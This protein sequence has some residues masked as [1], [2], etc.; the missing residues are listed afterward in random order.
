MMWVLA[1]DLLMGCLMRLDYSVWLSPPLHASHDNR[2]S[3]TSFNPITPTW[4]D[5]NS[6]TPFL[7]STS[8]GSLPLIFWYSFC[9]QRSVFYSLMSWKSVVSSI[10]LPLSFFVFFSDHLCLLPFISLL[11]L[12][13]TAGKNQNRIRKHCPKPFFIALSVK[14]TAF[15]MALA[16]NSLSSMLALAQIWWFI[17]WIN[18]LDQYPL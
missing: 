18:N 12:F 14:N 8:L 16:S 4:S 15:F 6:I 13:G 11:C 2:V 3:V 1:G 7:L 10:S 5:T 17:L 9:H